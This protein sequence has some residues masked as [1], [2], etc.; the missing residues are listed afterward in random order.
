VDILHAIAQF[1]PYFSFGIHAF[2]VNSDG[3]SFYSHTC[4]CLCCPF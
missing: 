1:P 4:F 2:V 3:V